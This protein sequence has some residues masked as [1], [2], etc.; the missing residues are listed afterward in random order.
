MNAKTN[1][2]GASLI[3]MLVIIAMLSILLGIGA[4]S[5]NQYLQRSRLNEASKVMGE[6]LRRVSELAITESQKF[7]VLI[8]SNT[9]AWKEMSTNIQRGSQ[10][11]PYNAVI[12]AKSS[13]SFI[14]SGRGI[15]VDPETFTVS[16]NSKNKKIYLF[17]TGAVS[18]Q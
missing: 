8:G 2:Q 6:T 7:E 1:Q 13:S 10:E 11:L 17:V 18:Y 15:P 5:L 4:F 14:F 12:S 9:I 3:E 16:L